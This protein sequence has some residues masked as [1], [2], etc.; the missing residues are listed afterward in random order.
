[1]SEFLFEMIPTRVKLRIMMM[2]D[3]T[4][5]VDVICAIFDALS[6]KI[7]INSKKMAKKFLISEIFHIFAL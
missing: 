6:K 4:N 1:M 5:S 3:G 2:R 7:Q